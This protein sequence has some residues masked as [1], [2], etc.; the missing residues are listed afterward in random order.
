MSKSITEIA[1]GIGYTLA[2]LSIEQR[3]EAASDLKAGRWPESL[4]AH[5]PADWDALTDAEKAGH[6]ELNIAREVVADA[7]R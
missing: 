1:Q 7:T 2:T 4:E 5:K 6:P 3:K